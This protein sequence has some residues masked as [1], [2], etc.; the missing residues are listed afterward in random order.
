MQRALIFALIR[1][2]AKV[3]K[4]E[5]Q[6][7]PDGDMSSRQASKSA[8]YIFEEP[9]LYLHPQ[10]QRELYDSL[11]ELS[12]SEN[13]V[14]LCTHSSSFLSLDK[15]KSICIIRK[16][17]SS[18][19]TTAFQCTATFLWMIKNKH[20]TWRIDKSRPERAYFSQKSFTRLKVPDKNNYSISCRF[21]G[22]ISL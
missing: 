1:T 5:R 9:E 18:E 13:Q 4:E 12:T 3:H 20:L 7:L 17:I 10:A 11:I 21:F 19:G 15:Y 22:L 14:I 6:A 2:L 16:T 8:Y